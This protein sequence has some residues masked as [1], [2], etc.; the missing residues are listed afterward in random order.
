MIIITEFIQKIFPHK[1]VYTLYSY[2]VYN[3]FM[4]VV[5][6]SFITYLLKASINL[7]IMTDSFNY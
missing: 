4:L 5:L 6:L 7:I 1:V 3:H 2:R